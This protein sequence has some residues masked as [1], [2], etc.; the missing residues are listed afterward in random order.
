MQK[1]TNDKTSLYF[2]QSLLLSI[3]SSVRAVDRKPR[4]V[5]PSTGGL[6]YLF[7]NG[8]ITA[9]VFQ[10]HSLDIL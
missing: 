8:M 5:L 9:P 6:L 7:S 4:V 10:N 1:K 2:I 3:I